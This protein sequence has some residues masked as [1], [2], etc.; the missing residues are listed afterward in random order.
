MMTKSYLNQT[1]YVPEEDK[2]V[3]RAIMVD[4]HIVVLGLM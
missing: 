4:I 3:D 2:R 1:Y